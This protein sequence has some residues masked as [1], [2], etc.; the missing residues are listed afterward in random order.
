MSPSALDLVRKLLVVDPKQRITAETVL[1]FISRTQT[2]APTLESFDVPS[3]Y[4]HLDTSVES[5][6][7]SD[8]EARFCVCMFT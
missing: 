2:L 1:T 7:Q 8:L 5:V 4:V 6:K 3:I